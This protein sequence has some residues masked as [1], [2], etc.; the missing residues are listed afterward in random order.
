MKKIF[1]LTALALAA[2]GVQ[3]QTETYSAVT[4]DQS[5]G[6][7]TVNADFGTTDGAGVFTPIKEVTT[8]TAN[9]TVHA[10]TS[11]A[12]IAF[13][14]PDNT[15]Y[16]FNNWPA[17]AYG[18]ATWKGNKL[19]IDSLDEANNNVGSY[20]P[21][22]VG[23]GNPA[24]EFYGCA[25]TKDGVETGN[26]YVPSK[27]DDGTHSG[28][29]VYYLPDGSKGVPVTGEYVELTAK[30]DGA[31]KVAFWANKGGN[32][33]LYIVQ[34]ST[35][36]ALDPTKDYHAEGWVQAVKDAKGN[37]RYINPMAITNYAFSGMVPDPTKNQTNSLGEPL[38]DEA[39]NPIPDSVD[40]ANRPKV[41]YLFFQA[42]AGETY[43]LIGNSWQF[44]FQGYEFTPGVD[45]GVS[46]IAVT[47]NKVAPAYNLA[48]QRVSATFKGVVIRNGKKYMQR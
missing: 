19:R 15:Y 29:Y 16:D 42:K 48:G 36:K 31:F 34:K 12:P 17:E 21:Y 28:G 41:G 24:I 38:L 13:A 5:T 30:V 37:M 47:D 39:G 25:E 9:V 35:K 2:L 44:G 26:W 18:D 43:M 22:V 3:A 20:F 23:N 46:A 14:N 32:R 1:T 7:V 6:T 11:G 4:V 33:A 45:A 10:L 8:G 27:E 40:I